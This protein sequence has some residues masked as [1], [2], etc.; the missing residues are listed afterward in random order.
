MAIY[1]ADQVTMTIERSKNICGKYNMVIFISADHR[2]EAEDIARLY[3][4]LAIGLTPNKIDVTRGEN[5]NNT[6]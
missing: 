4:Y 3:Q 5:V 1:G 6:T 2:L